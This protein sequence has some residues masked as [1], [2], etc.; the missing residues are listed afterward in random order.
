MESER[1]WF[2]SESPP[3]TTA[4]YDTQRIANI[5]QRCAPG[6]RLGI[7]HI[8]FIQGAEDAGPGLA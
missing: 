5:A 2:P 4:L 1:H 7:A 6:S 8:L 3:L